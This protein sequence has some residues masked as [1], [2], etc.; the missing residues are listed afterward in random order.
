[1]FTGPSIMIPSVWPV[2]YAHEIPDGES[3]S[4]IEHFQRKTKMKE[5][6]AVGSC[7]HELET[8]PSGSLL[9]G[10]DC[11]SSAI[12]NTLKREKKRRNENPSCGIFYLHLLF[13]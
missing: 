11:R 10:V 2:N 5:I 9:R 7:S 6:L 4:S 8:E 12:G 1:M 3:V 13:F